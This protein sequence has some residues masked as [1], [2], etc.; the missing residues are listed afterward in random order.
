M[1]NCEIYITG[2]MFEN[3]SWLDNP[4]TLL[5]DMYNNLSDIDSFYFS[6]LSLDMAE[7][8][9]VNLK[10]ANYESMNAIIKGAKYKGQ[11]FLTKENLE[12]LKV[13]I[14]KQL[15]YIDSLKFQGI[16]FRCYMIYPDY[17]LGFPLR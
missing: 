7:V 12:S 15:Q 6:K 14:I 10:T 17:A 13:E 3:Q 1:E 2:I 5:E 4:D 9:N 8:Y 11:E 16:E